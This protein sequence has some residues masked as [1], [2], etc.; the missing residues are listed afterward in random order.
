MNKI[1][2]K[3]ANGTG[4]TLSAVVRVMI[5]ARPGGS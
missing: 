3:S 4:I 1:S 5:R 2:I